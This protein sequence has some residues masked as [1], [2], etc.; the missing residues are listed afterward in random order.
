MDSE[1]PIGE[2]RRGFRRWIWLIL[3]PVLLPVLGFLLSNLWLATPWAHHWIAGKIQKR[4]GLETRVGGTS[5][6]PWN[7]ISID[8]VELL[9]P[10]ALRSAIPKPFARIGSIQL[11]PVWRAWVRGRLEVRSITLDTPDLTLPLE[12]LA[13]LSGPAPQVSPPAQAA[14]PPPVAQVNP[15]VTNPPAATPP[16][17]VTVAP[18]QVAIPPQPT[19]WLYLKNASFSLVSVGRKN[20]LLEI[21]KITGALPID[22]DPAQSDLKIDSIAVAGNPA[23]SNLS[24]SLEWKRPQL[25]MKP[26][27]LEFQGC[28]FLL[29]GKI[30][31][32]GGLPLQIEAQI[33]QQKPP[34]LRL[35]LDGHFEAETIAANAVFRGLLVAPSTWQGDLVAETIAPSLHLAGH[36]AKFDKGSTV[37]ILRGGMLSCVDARLIGDELSLLGNATVLSN[38]DAAGVLRVVAPPENV[39]NIVKNAFPNIQSPSL[40]PLSTPQ[41]AA[42]D[43]EA[44]GNVSHPFLRLGKDGPIMNLKIAT[45][46]P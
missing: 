24:A 11:S 5:W 46:S 38:G 43:L 41:R 42:F 17:A 27:G 45:P 1:A 21:S 44:F 9:Q 8:S 32:L 14:T 13:H 29:A 25:A 20:P 39:G 31:M 23:F 40:T 37:T 26:L 10:P 4:T 16:P 3:T 2:R 34:T 12:L 30:F 28:K 35:P 7:G 15:P 33:P 36:D 19:G 18:P 22:G 6:S